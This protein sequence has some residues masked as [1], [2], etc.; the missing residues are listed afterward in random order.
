M[1][2]KYSAIALSGFGA[3][4]LL[5][6]ITRCHPSTRGGIFFVI[7]V[8]LVVAALVGCANTIG[9]YRQR[10][11]W[12]SDLLMIGIIPVG[13]FTLLGFIAFFAGIYAGAG[14]HV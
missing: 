6:I 14:C 2:L 1:I 8:A 7:L 4:Q 13:V 9:L 11:Y 10:E 12:S 3:F 5:G